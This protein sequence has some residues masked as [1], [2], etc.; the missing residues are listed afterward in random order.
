M[1]VPGLRLW[2][3]LRRRSLFRAAFPEPS[4]FTILKEQLGEAA[5]PSSLHFGECEGKALRDRKK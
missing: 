4:F 1:N 2:L 5:A 3:P